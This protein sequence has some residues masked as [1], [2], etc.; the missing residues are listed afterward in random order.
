MSVETRGEP[1]APRARN[2]SRSGPPWDS[3]LGHGGRRDP[4]FTGNVATVSS[5]PMA[6]GGSGNGHYGG[7]SE[8][9]IDVDLA[10]GQAMAKPLKGEK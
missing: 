5:H 3:P 2:G 10:M 7:N 4:Q 8:V 1:A 6:Q 9:S